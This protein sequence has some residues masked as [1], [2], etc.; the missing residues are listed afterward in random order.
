MADT[1]EN[2]SINVLDDG[3]DVERGQYS[4]IVSYVEDRFERAKD[5]R[6]HDESRWLQ[7]YRNY[8]GIYGPDVQFTETEKSR[9]FIKVTKTKVLAAYGQLI[10]VLFS[11]NKFPISVD[12]TTLPEGVVDSV[13]LDP[14][15]Q[16]AEQEFKDRFGFEGDDD[17]TIT[18]KLG[19]LTEDLKD[20]DSLEEGPGATPTSITFEPA[21]VAAKKMEKKIKDQLEESAATRHLRFSCFEC[22]TFGTGIMKGPFAFDK[23]YSNWGDDGEYNPIM[24]TVP[25]VEYTSIW[26][27]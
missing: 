18:D 5:A 10:D 9:V 6:Y 27:F 14:A 13:T 7:A 26:T 8:R 23:E 17:P 20:F 2:D 1:Y 15:A 12:P 25:Q 16:A 19:P 3:E 21:M 24:K 11:Q 4:N 22:V